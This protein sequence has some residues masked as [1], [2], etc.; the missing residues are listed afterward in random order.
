MRPS[1]SAII[2]RLT[3][4]APHH[5]CSDQ[6][7]FVCWVCGSP[8]ARGI[9]RYKWMGANFTGQN[10]VRCPSSEHVCEPCVHVTA[11]K[12][13][14]T[15]RMWSHLVEGDQHLRLNKG[16]KAAMRQFLF[17]YHKD[18]WFAAIADSGKK[19]IVPW[20]PV[21][22]PGKSGSV[23]F[24]ETVVDIPEDHSLVDEISVLLTLGATK[25][26]MAT[27]NY[28]ARAWQLCG[29]TLRNFEERH[30][31]ERH[32]PWFDLALWLAQRDE[33]AVAVRL[34]AE[35]AATAAKKAA[36]KARKR[37][38][39]K[40]K[41]PNDGATAGAARRVSG[42]ARVQRTKALGPPTEHDAVIVETERNTGGM[43]N[44]DVPQ[45]AAGSAP[46][47]QLEMF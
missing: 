22:T 8:S 25:E 30:G 11:G 3:G 29:D 47:K 5:L 9:Q 14:D 42:N 12:P 21:N 41:K 18:P 35:R 26:E 36:E 10:K 24:E 37:G 28:G 20:C 7:P 19:H 32:G 4:S 23:L 40:A 27:G 15:E 44:P 2:H 16:S 43:D 46:R 34:E 33:E 1:P 17:R 39:G 38:Q 31:G 45:V 6:R 13:P